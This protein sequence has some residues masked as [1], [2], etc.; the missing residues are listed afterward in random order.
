LRTRMP[1]NQRGRGDAGQLG[2]H[3]LQVKGIVSIE[4]RSIIEPAVSGI[5]RHSIG[6]QPCEAPVPRTTGS[7]RNTQKTIPGNTCGCPDV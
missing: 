4:I 5:L 7:P 1:T 3:R 6:N 2:Q